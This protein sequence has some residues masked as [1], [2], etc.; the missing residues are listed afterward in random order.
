MAEIL[1]YQVW[2]ALYQVPILAFKNADESFE[3]KKNE[4]QVTVLIC[5]C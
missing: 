4:S 5:D 1:Y 3:E 2:V